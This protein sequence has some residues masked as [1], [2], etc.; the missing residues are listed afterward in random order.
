M[1]D[2]SAI[3]GQTASPTEN[4]RTRLADNFDNFLTLLTTQ[5]QNQDPLAPMDSNEFTNQLVSFAEVEQSLNTNSQLEQL[6]NI[7]KTGRAAGA[8]GFLGTTIQADG[9]K[10]VLND[11]Y[12]E[13]RYSLTGVANSTVIK[14][15]NS[16]GELV[17]ETEGDRSSGEHTFLW[18]GRDNQGN[19]AGDGVYQ[20]DVIAKDTK[21]ESLPVTTSTVG[22]VTGIRQDGENVL[23]FIDGIGVPLDDVKSIDAPFF[24]AGPGYADGEDGESETPASDDEAETAASDEEADTAT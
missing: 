14:I 7:Q 13:A 21:G 5:L 2:V 24:V 16:K 1:A 18:D 12:G 11:G 23:L 20:I 17:L 6:V 9:D 8:V 3:T 22:T 19:Y 10:L 15:Y 4:A